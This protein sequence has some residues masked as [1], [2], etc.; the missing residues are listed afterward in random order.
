M[1]KGHDHEPEWDF[2]LRYKGLV[3]R[4]M[5]SQIM[6]VWI[7]GPEAVDEVLNRCRRLMPLIA[8]VHTI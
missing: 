4:T 7:G 8:W 5:E 3:V 1:P 2:L 6:P